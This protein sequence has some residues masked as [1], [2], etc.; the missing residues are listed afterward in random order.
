MP[1]LG[2]MLLVRF[3]ALEKPLGQK[4]DDLDAL[5]RLIETLKV[6]DSIFNTIERLV[7]HLYCV[8][9]KHGINNARYKKLS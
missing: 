8:Q 1:F 2:A 6:D 4:E 9:K 7:C 5:R 3:M